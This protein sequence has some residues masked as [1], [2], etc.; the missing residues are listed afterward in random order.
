M[1]KRL[2][3]LLSVAVAAVTANAQTG[4]SPYGATGYPYTGVLTATNVHVRCGAG[5]VNGANNY[6]PCARLSSPARVQV[7]G[8]R[9]GW[10][11]IDPPPGCYS[12]II[13]SALAVDI[14]GTEGTVTRDRV[15]VR[16]AG[17][18]RAARFTAGQMRLRRGQRVKVF[19]E[20]TDDF[21]KW[22]KIKPPRGVYFWI[23]GEFVTK[24]AAVTPVPTTGAATTTQP[25][26]RLAATQPAEDYVPAVPKETMA[27]FRAAQRAITAEYER[28]AGRRDLTALIEQFEA[29]KVKPKSPLKPYVDF[30]IQYMKT[31]IARGKDLSAAENLR[32]ESLERQ[33]R[34]DLERALAEAAKPEEVMPYTAE[35]ILSAS[36]MFPG[37]ALTKRYILTDPAT[38]RVNAYVEA[39]AEDVDLDANVG[40]HVGIYGTRQYDRKLAIDIVKAEQVIVIGEDVKVPAP[41]EPVVKPMP[42]P[43]IMPA[44]K[45]VPETR[46]A[47]TTKPRPA[48]TPRP[49]IEPIPLEDIKPTTRPKPAPVKPAPV[50]PIPLEDLKPASAAPR[51]VP[52]TV[53]PEPIFETEPETVA[54]PRPK[55]APAA[56]T[57][58]PKPVSVAAPAPVRPRPVEA[59]VKPKPVTPAL[60]VPAGAMAKPLPVVKPKP[61]AVEKPGPLAAPV[62]KPAA[63]AP[64]PK[65]VRPALMAVPRGPTPLVV[66]VFKDGTLKVDGKPVA[67]KDLEAIFR[68]AGAA[69]PPRTLVVRS[70]E[71]VGLRQ[72]ARVLDIA[73]RCGITNVRSETSDVALP[74]IKPIPLESLKPGIKPAPTSRP[75]TQPAKAG[76]F[77]RPLPP[78]GLPMVEPEKKPTTAPVDEGEYE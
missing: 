34:F 13:R 27:A 61:A 17:V 2:A 71:D 35:G 32:Q 15:W 3:I 39:G 26:T 48:V 29:I 43:A 77:P 74:A 75:S 70:T 53:E 60:P 45:P 25:A 51:P 73:Q 54:T 22:Y 30:Y 16:A 62:P 59:A 14:T 7:F 40:N 9:N 68:K 65:P 28:P 41:P 52:K 47:A 21:G 36:R 76:D 63:G 38:R 33:K 12:V 23:Y 55:I 19:G 11:K 31:D 72:I 24:A 57:A 78:S 49:I 5:D 42:V 1:T 46:P 50:K 6:Y 37:G 44:L 58:R 69:K 18:L 64:K 8:E 66:R 67:K 10:L 56:P 20:V 4:P